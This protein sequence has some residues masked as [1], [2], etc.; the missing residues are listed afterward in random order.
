MHVLRTTAAAVMLWAAA[1][2]ADAVTMTAP[3][4]A[5]IGYSQDMMAHHQQAVLMASM[6]R[7][8]AG[9]RVA[10]LALQIELTQL[11]QI[12]VLS[13]F[14]AAWGQPTLP[15]AKDAAMAGMGIDDGM[16]TAAELA[17]LRDASGPALD[18]TFLR[19]MIRHH[20]GAVAMDRTA[21]HSGRTPAVRDFARADLVEE[22]G[23]I[24]Y[25]R[26]LLDG[27]T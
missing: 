19:L 12:G 1:A 5:D 22:L 13:G 3:G 16:A 10:A 2:R 14:L 26:G 23:E 6:T 8:R 25:M 17:E 11:Q 20:E 24:A 15:P 21:A 18:H 7:E 4:P 9:P 27:T